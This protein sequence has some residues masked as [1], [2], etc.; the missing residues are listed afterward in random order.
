MELLYIARQRQPRSGRPTRLFRCEQNTKEIML[1]LVTWL[2]A[3]VYA[4]R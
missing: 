1:R 3:H 2:Q 4:A